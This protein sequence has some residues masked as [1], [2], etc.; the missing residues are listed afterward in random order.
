MWAKNL[1]DRYME[2]LV[3][4]YKGDLKLVIEALDW[5]YTGQDPE[6]QVKEQHKNAN[7]NW[8]N[9]K[10]NF[11]QKYG[12]KSNTDVRSA[13]VDNFRRQTGIEP[14]GEDVTGKTNWIKDHIAGLPPDQ[15]SAL[16]GVSQQ[17]G[18]VDGFDAAQQNYLTYGTGVEPMGAAVRQHAGELDSQ[19]RNMQTQMG[20]Q[21][22][23]AGDA[24]YRDIRGMNPA[25]QQSALNN[26]QDPAMRNYVETRLEA[27]R[28]SNI[29]QNQMTPEGQAEL[30]RRRQEQLEEARQRKAEIESFDPSANA[31]KYISFK[32][33]LKSREEEL[34]DKEEESIQQI[35]IE[36][37]PCEHGAADQARIMAKHSQNQILERLP[38]LQAAGDAMEEIKSEIEKLMKP[39]AG[40]P[41]RMNAL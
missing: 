20:P 7:K 12:G 32:D 31:E 24:A 39:K 18:D 6:E 17:L 33:M 36:R 13:A 8:A 3:N 25:D 21:M 40:P 37:K 22:T 35:M 2:D 23:G 19:I 9:A 27:H 26:I 28:V 14:G 10:K 5:M 30:E 38:M 4:L 11:N 34:V 16:S 29:N 15:Q 41:D 1:A